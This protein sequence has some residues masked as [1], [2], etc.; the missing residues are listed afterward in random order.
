VYASA[1]RAA[2]L[3]QVTNKS[4]L[5]GPGVQDADRPAH[6]ERLSEPEGA[7]RPPVQLKALRVVT[8]P[9][10]LDGIRGH[11]GGRRYLGQRPTVRPPEPQ[12]RD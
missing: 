1:V 5:H 9:Q 2:I 3:V 10:R 7:C 6:V 4:R 11:G 8:R 12:P